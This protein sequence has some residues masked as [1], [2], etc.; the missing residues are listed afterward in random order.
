MINEIINRSRF[1]RKQYMMLLGLSFCLR[2]YK[3]I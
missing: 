2:S 1:A 3:P